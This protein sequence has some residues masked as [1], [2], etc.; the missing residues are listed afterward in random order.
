M[1][2]LCINHI[3]RLTQIKPIKKETKNIDVMMFSTTRKLEIYDVDLSE[4]SEKFKIDSKLKLRSLKSREKHTVITTKT[5]IQDY[6]RSV[7]T[8][9]RYKHE[10]RRYKTKTTYTYDIRS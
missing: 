2:L 1:K 6:H 3:V 4:L 9:S 5:K 10:R 8:F 7:Q